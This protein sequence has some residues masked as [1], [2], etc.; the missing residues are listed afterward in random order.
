M[1]LDTTRLRGRPKLAEEVKKLLS[2]VLQKVANKAS[3]QLA[4]M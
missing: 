1:N 3:K 2:A 4:E